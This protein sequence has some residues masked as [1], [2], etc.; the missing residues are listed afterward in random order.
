M[1]L[2][3]ASLVS[4]RVLSMLLRSAVSRQIG[5]FHLSG[6]VFGLESGRTHRLT[7]EAIVETTVGLV[8]RSNLDESQ[9]KPNR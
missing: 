7:A 3:R 5:A 2:L 8:K 9:G 6:D 4:Q 1:D